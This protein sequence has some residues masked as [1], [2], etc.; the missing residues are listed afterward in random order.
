MKEIG[1]PLYAGAGTGPVKTAQALANIASLLA[2]TSWETGIF[3]NCDETNY[4]G[5]ETAACTQREDGQRY[6]SLTQAPSCNVDPNM[7]MIAETMASWAQSNPRMEC[8]PGTST[9]GCCWWGRGAIQ[10]T[11]PHNYKM[12]QVEVVDK[13]SFLKDIDIDLCSNPEAIC[14]QDALK[15]LGALYYWTSIV[16]TATPFI[17]SLEHFVEYGFQSDASIVGGASFNDGTGGMVNNGAWDAEAHGN[18]GRSENFEK[19]VAA[20]K[21]AGMDAGMVTSAPPTGCALCGS[22]S[23][24]PNCYVA[25]WSQ[26]CFSAAS[27]GEC[28]QQSGE[29]CGIAT[30]TEPATTKA[31]TTMPT[32]TTM[33]ALYRF[34]GDGLC[35]RSDDDTL[36]VY[37]G[38]SDNPGTDN[39]TRI[40]ACAYA[41]L[42]QHTPKDSL[43]WTFTADRFSIA[44]KV[45]ATGFGRCYCTQASNCNYSSNYNAFYT[46]FDLVPQA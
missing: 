14:Q 25:S 46:T 18:E 38:P 5:W 13:V 17:E 4:R 29:W 45:D 42:E 10:T 39:Q 21:A 15:W 9:E 11:G 33:Q 3:K 27:Q 36:R 22:M 1:K 12:L 2:Q 30:T 23:P 8:K 32:T 35:V 26:P 28:S 44:N 7:H 19:F 40:R 31:L 20:F 37:D 34:A 6:D 24:A 43:S 41:C 16:Q